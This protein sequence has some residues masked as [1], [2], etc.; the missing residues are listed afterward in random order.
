MFILINSQ[1]SGALTT[2]KSLGV[3]TVHIWNKLHY[4]VTIIVGLKERPLK[5]LSV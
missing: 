1:A 3:T 5:S 4:V 2:L